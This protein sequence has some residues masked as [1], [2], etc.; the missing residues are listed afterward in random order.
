MVFEKD[1]PA[2][3]GRAR[4]VAREQNVYLLIG[5]GTVFPGTAR[6]FENKALVIGTAGAIVLSYA[7]A[8]P[9]PGFEAAMPAYGVIAT[10]STPS[11]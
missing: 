6:P 1:E 8:I 7:K 11:L 9:V 3:L 4:D 5:V 10:L 2:L